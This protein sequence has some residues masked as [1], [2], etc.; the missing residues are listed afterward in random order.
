[1]TP[2]FYNEELLRQATAIAFPLVLDA[3]AKINRFKKKQTGKIEKTRL[4]N[5]IR[6]ARLLARSEVVKKIQ[7]EIN[8]NKHLARA[9]VEIVLSKARESGDKE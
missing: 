9:A 6:R 1:M 2:A 5:W 4:N 7:R 3:D 8:I